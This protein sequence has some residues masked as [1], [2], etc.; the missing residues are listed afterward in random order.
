MLRVLHLVGSPT[1]EFLAELSR[2][3]ARGCLAATADPDRYEPVIAHVSPDGCWRFPTTVDTAAPAL[4]LPAALARIR[5]L[6]PDVVIP[7]MFCL[8]GMTSYRALFDVLGVPV[9]GNPPEVMALGADKPRARALVAHGGVD[10]PDGRVVTSASPGAVPELPVVVKPA[11]SDNSL[12]VTLVRRPEQYGPA[13]GAALGHSGAAL[14][15]TYVP[16]GREVRCGVI[17]HRG[18][19]VCLPLEE[20]PVDEDAAPVRLP[21]DKLARD[22]DGGLGLVAK[23]ADRAW[24]VSPDDPV[25]GPVHE[26]ARRCHAALGCRDYGLFD[27][28]VDPAG[29]PWF[30]EAG[31][32]CSFAPTSVIVAMA[33]R[34]GVPLGE[35]FA[36]MLGRAAD[37]GR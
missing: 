34:A 9:V 11:D 5:E 33:E 6:P 31:L 10:V 32:Y 29:R 1:S 2:L 19:L 7:Q 17:E 4:D 12:G 30:L 21:A 3:Y 37:R 27:F 25:V 23:G 18:E 26:A 22:D 14:V 13:L 24:A 28:R 36:E 15:E 16:A 20:Y 35:L 8:P